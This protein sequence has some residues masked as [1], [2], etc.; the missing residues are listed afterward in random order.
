MEW[1]GKEIRNRGRCLFGV[2][3][4]VLPQPNSRQVIP[5]K[6]ALDCVRALV[7]FNMMAQYQSHIPKTIA[8][9]EEYLAP[10]SQDETYLLGVSS[11]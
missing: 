4:V 7:D 10:V 8:Y 9:M 3:A 2:L 5:F 1:Q 6:Y 11:F